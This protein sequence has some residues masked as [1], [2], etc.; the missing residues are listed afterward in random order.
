[1]ICLRARLLEVDASDSGDGPGGDRTEHYGATHQGQAVGGLAD[2]KEHPQRI[3]DRLQHKN[4]V[5]LE[6]R[7]LPDG[8]RI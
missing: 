4:R 6:R 8:D 7:N 5:G 2:D 3:E 1:M